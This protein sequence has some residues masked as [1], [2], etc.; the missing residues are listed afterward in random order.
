MSLRKKQQEIRR[1][2]KAFE[3]ES[4][5]FHDFTFS[6][7]GI[8]QDGPDSE[9]KFRNPNH[10]IMLWQYY[11]KVVS[12]DGG[13]KDLLRSL[14]GS[15]LKWG[16]RGAE[17]SLY[18]VLEGAACPLFI[19]MASRA[20]SL[21]N[22]KEALLIKT[23]LEY[24][25]STDRESLQSGEKIVTTTNDHPLA[26]WLNYL[27][28]HL[29]VSNPGREHVERI[30]PDPFTLSLL[31][32]E[33]L[34]EDLSVSRSD[35]SATDIRNIHFSVAL[36]FPG[37][38]RTYVSEVV[39]ALRP[40]LQKDALFYD[41]DYQA[42]LACPNLD[43]LLQDIYGNRAD[44]LVVFLEKDYAIRD[45]CGIEW[46]AIREIIKLKQDERIMLVRF[47]QAKVDGIFSTDGYIDASK[48]TPAKLAR[49]IMDRLGVLVTQ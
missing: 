32:L 46:R 7:Y 43:T 19:R 6:V 44:L 12:A 3:N 48:T 15:D 28:F 42:Q 24:Q 35:R 38:V 40:R 20:G 45:W 8:S 22:D 10:A 27:L 34:A 31:A 33:R 30:E 11:G 49:F 37:T 47:D 14:Q 17:F 23:R 25:L 13:A 16:V 1:L 26:I 36:S 4:N 41:F 29:S 9:R 5:K 39:Q 2:L 18:G 21:F